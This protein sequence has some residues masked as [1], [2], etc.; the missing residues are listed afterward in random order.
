MKV[1]LAIF[2]AMFLV[3]CAPHSDEIRANEVSV[4]PYQDLSCTEIH[5]QLNTN[6]IKLKALA[7]SIDKAAETD[8]AQTAVGVVIFWPILFALEGSETPESEIYAQLRGE[9]MALEHTAILKD[10]KAAVEVAK[11]WHEEEEQARL[12]KERTKRERQ[13]WQESGDDY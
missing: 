3:A 6:I 10:C 5:A 4:E 1:L 9:C 7:G 12:Q 11:I 8:E 2:A 13:S